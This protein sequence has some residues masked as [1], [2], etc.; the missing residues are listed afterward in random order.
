MVFLWAALLLSKQAMHKGLM[1]SVQGILDESRTITFSITFSFYM[2]TCEPY[3]NSMFTFYLPPLKTVG[4]VNSSTSVS[5]K[6]AEQR[7][8]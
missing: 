3:T 7:L 2:G 6:H 1:D 4:R 8:E 5:F